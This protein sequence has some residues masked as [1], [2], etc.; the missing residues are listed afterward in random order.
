[1]AAGIEGGSMTARFEK[2]FTAAGI[3]EDSMATRIQ[4]DHFFYDPQSFNSKN[5]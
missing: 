4:M 5:H 2:E 3:V 1:M